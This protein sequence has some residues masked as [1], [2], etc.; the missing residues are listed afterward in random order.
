M[1][2]PVISVIMLTYNREAFISRSIE[3]ILAQTYRDFEFI[4]VDNGST[5]RSGDIADE[6]AAQDL[7][8]RVIHKQRGNIGSGRNA[9][10]DEAKGEYIAFIDDDDWC[11]SDFLAFLLTLAVEN[12]ADISICGS[13]DKAYDEKHVYEP[14]EALIELLWRKRFNVQFPTKLIRRKLFDAHRFSE[15]SKYDDIELMPSI[16]ASTNQIAYHGL[17]KYTFVR[18]SGNNSAWTTNHALLNAETLSEYLSIYNSRTKMLTERF[19]NQASYWQYFNLSFQISM[20][21]KVTRLKC[22]IAPI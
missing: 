8:I 15:V 4:I 9:G 18:H 3:S 22:P 21:E 7:R 12:N 2:L 13:Y 1:A 20:V 10:L 6:Y 16:M 19:P 17:C 11:T 14:E 5:D